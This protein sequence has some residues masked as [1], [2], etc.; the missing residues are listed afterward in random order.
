MKHIRPWPTSTAAGH[1]ARN[2][3]SDARI[4]P[5][6]RG[7]IVW[8]QIISRTSPLA[9]PAVPVPSATGPGHLIRGA[10]KVFSAA[11][12]AR[13]AAHG[14]AI[15]HYYYLRALFEQDG[16]TPA[17]LSARIR[18]DRATVTQVLDTMER[19]GLVRRERHQH[20]RRKIQI[21]LTPAGEELREPVLACIA[22]VNADALA[23]ISSDD[24]ERFRRTL[25]ALTTNLEPTPPHHGDLHVVS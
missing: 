24:F 7:H 21:F 3:F 12:A 14:V 22:G 4:G 16:L 2:N 19:Q 15:N 18:M 6:I 5:V 10:Q 9:K 13:L 8:G 23:G 20:D 25:H 17:E 11:L 1:P